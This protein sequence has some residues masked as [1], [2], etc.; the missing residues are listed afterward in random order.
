MKK[1][2]LDKIEQ[3]G[4]KP[5]ANFFGVSVGTISNWHSG[6]TEP[7]L[8][9]AQL[10][11][12]DSIEEPN[13][14]DDPIF[15]APN[16][17]EQVE[18]N[19]SGKK[20]I[21]LLPVY[22]GFSSDTHYTLFANYAKYGPEKIGMIMEKRTVIHESRN[23][24]AHKALK[25]DAEMVIMVDDDMILP[26]GSPGVWSSRFGCDIDP[27][28]SGLNAITR[29]MS[30]GFDKRIVGALYFGRHSRGK[31][32][33]CS[34][35]SSDRENENFRKGVYTGLKTEEWVGTGFIRIHRNV[36]EE[37]KAAIDGGKFPECKP[38]NESMWYGFFNPLRVG[39]GE[40]VSFGRRAAELGIQSY[41]DGGLVCLHAGEVYFGPHNTKS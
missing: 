11:M 29:I 26:C 4:V 3:L 1:A 6:K 32:Q 33:C 22:R 2:V 38:L 24:L 40:D 41:V 20:V 14:G 27:K 37:M 21:I 23:I 9:A 35:F 25:T 39:V 31:A 8:R 5:S 17:T 36:F 28:I 18:V 13:L 7:S 30:H 15:E 16:T 10:A 34:G 12:A 19:W